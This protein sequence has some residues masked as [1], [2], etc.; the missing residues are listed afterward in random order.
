MKMPV[1]GR[2]ASRRSCVFSAASKDSAYTPSLSVT[3]GID[4]VLG[5]KRTCDPQPLRAIV[6]ETPPNNSW[7]PF[8]APL[9][10]CAS[11]MAPAQVPQTGLVFKNFL[12]G[13]MSPARRA[14]KAIVVDSAGKTLVRYS[15]Q[16][17]DVTY[18]LQE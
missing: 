10:P 2:S 3:F 7:P 15:F 11:R 8:F 12:R 9:T 18:L 17:C 13:S 14:N 6:I 16:A 5:S 1:N 4:Q